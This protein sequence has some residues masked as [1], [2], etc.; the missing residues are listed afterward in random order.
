M[1]K[2]LS[3]FEEEITASLMLKTLHFKLPKSLHSQIPFTVYAIITQ[4]TLFLLY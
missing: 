4:R 2:K 3:I 1:N